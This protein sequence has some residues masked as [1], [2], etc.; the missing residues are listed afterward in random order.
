M[1]ITEKTKLEVD[2][3]QPTISAG[4]LLQHRSLWQ[5]AW[6]RLRRDRF[7]ILGGI[8][9]LCLIGVAL[10]A[11][12]LAPHDP[13]M[14]QRDGL[15]FGQPISP[16]TQYWLGTDQLGRDMLSRL[17]WGGR[18]SLLVG[19]VGNGLAVLIGVTLGATAAFTG[20]W[21]D[22]SLMRFTDVIMGFPVLLLAVA[23]ISLLRP[24]L[25]IVILVIGLVYW[26][27]LARIVYGQV[28]SLRERDFVLAARS[29][30]CRVG[31]ILFWHLLPHVLSL[32][33][34]YMTLGTAQAIILESTL[35]FLGIGIQPPTP[36]WGNMISEGQ[37]Y[38]RAAPWLV[39]YPGLA[40]V[41]TVLGFNLLGD[42]LRDALDP[43]QR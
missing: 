13:A 43:R 11:P 10:L 21:V 29:I 36:S 5:D 15:M 2:R 1:S 38:Y 12:W 42:G 20:G 9:V 3:W 4:Q 22:T 14:Q 41:L 17:L 27:Y 31:R 33:I 6:L 35:S 39:L 40:I 16:N 26:T 25:G 23:L 34:V 37:R 28:K 7:A 8:I 30:G 24:S 18:I 19:I 32:A